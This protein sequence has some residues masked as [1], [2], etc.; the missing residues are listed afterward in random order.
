MNISAVN[1]NLY[2]YQT[3]AQ[4]S[5][6][7]QRAQ[8]FKALQSALQSGDLS[9][10]QQAFASLQQDLPGTAQIANGSNQ[11]NPV[12]KVSQDFQALQSALQSGDLATAQQAF[13]TLQQDLQS[14]HKAHHHHHH[15]PDSSAPTQPGNASSSST[16]ALAPTTT[17]NQ[18][19]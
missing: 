13:S 16:T 5:T 6:F 8:D 17:L 15:A 7:Q 14:A 19:A 2:E 1:S 3:A 9:G 4:Q 10:A 11:S 18:L 12:S